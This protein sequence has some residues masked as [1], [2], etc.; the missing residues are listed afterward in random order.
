MRFPIAAL[1]LTLA[2]TSIPGAAT[3]AAEEPFRID[4][5]L[6]QTG[7]A[8]FLGATETK[9][10]AILEGVL[11]KHGGINGRPIHFVVSDDGSAPP[12]AVTIFNQMMQRKPAAF[13]GTGFT[14]TCNA[15]QALV[16]DHGPVMYCLS[17]SLA[18]VPGGY[19]FA[20][21]VWTYY[22]ARVMLRYY[23][24][25][26]WNRVALITSTDASGSEFNNAFTYAMSLPENK[27]L[28]MVASAGHHKSRNL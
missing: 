9:S 6:S 4:A 2:L 17:P 11:N 10:L 8:A 26:H 28:T 24:E 13:I 22:L 25:R 5:I 7:P 23:R 20:G 1:A 3:R 16:K 14:A 12:A 27:G 21:S 18:P 15:L 19:A